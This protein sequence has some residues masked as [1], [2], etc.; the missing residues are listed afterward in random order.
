VEDEKKEKEFERVFVDVGVKIT[1]KLMKSVVEQQFIVVGTKEE[2][3][4][5]L[6]D[7]DAFHALYHAYRTMESLEEMIPPGLLESL[8]SSAL[9]SMEEEVTH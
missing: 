7:G 4:A 1:K 3:V 8:M 2:P 9:A 6:V 5:F